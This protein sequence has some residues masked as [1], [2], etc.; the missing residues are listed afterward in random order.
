[1]DT[2]H[3]QTSDNKHSAQHISN[4][5]QDVRDCPGGRVPG[6]GLTNGISTA[7][8]IHE[9]TPRSLQLRGVLELLPRP[10]HRE[11]AKGPV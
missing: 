10:P 2:I 1:M 9:Q 8:V 4:T 3:S 6:R 7:H 11:K 5:S